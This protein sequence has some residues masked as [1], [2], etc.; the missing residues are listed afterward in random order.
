MNT[1]KGRHFACIWDSLRNLWCFSLLVF[2]SGVLLAQETT[3]E[4]SKPVI[5]IGIVVREAARSAKFLTNVIG[6]KETGG[7]SVTAE[8]GRKIGLIDGHP[9]N[10]RVFLLDDGD[11]ATRIKLL[12]FPDAPGKQPDQ[13]N[14]HVTLGMRYLTLYVKS[15]NRA[16]DR[17][18]QAGVALQG[19]SP[20]DLGGGNYL[21]VIKDPDG[22]FYELIGPLK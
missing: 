5:D 10:V 9:V 4:F 22:N 15:M 1:T 13:S 16:L 3:N 20:V 7:F 19:E 14:I 17:I 2:S 8:M 11:R 6:F 21:T 18:K 12:A